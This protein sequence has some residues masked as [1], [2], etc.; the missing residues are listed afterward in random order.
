MSPR[1]DLRI[2]QRQRPDETR[3][4]SM[5][6]VGNWTEVQRRD[7][8]C[9]MVAAMQF[10]SP[11]LLCYFARSFRF[12]LRQGQRNQRSR[13]RWRTPIP[14]IQRRPF[15]SE[16][17]GCHA[18]AAA[19]CSTISRG[20]GNITVDSYGLTTQETFCVLGSAMGRARQASDGCLQ[21]AHSARPPFADLKRHQSA[22]TGSR[23]SDGSAG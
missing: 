23:V 14:L 11:Q 12:A 7:E 21:Y 3:L 8:C 19:P 6:D 4:V 1:A 9:C 18:D 17:S 2:R 10:H 13:V 22:P 16:P 15:G 5:P 20:S